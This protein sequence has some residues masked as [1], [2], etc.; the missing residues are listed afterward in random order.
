MSYLRVS[1]DRQGASGLGLEAQREAVARLVLSRGAATDWAATPDVVGRP[2]PRTSKEI[3]ERLLLA[4]FVEIE[5]GKN[6]ERPEFQE[7]KT[8]A[9]ITGA[10]LI[11]AKLDRLSRDAMFI[12]KLAKDGVKFVC[13]DMPEANELTIG[14]LAV[15]AQHEL[16]MIGR[17]TKEALAAAKARGVKLGNPNGAMSLANAAPHDR[18]VGARQA[19]A[20]CRAEKLRSTIDRFRAEGDVSLSA[21]ARRLTEAEAETPRKKRWTAKAVSRTLGWLGEK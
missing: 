9:E 18:G 5:S 14:L 20:R 17:R 3:L 15:V 4:E 8:R 6:D 16:K 2:V 1:T 11:V 12:M 19:K 7:A 13:A 10:T 21:L